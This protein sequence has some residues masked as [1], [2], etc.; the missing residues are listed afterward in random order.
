MNIGEG[1]FG[2]VDLYYDFKEDRLLAIKTFQE[3]VV[4]PKEKEE[5]IKVVMEGFKN[6]NQFNDQ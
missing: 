4:K 2:R 6:K 3:I 1:A 5:E